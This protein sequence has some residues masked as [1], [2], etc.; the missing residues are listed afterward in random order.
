L[1]GEG[2][3]VI[4]DSKAA[5]PAAIRRTT[6]PESVDT[7]LAMKQ[8]AA[9]LRAKARHSPAIL[10]TASAYVA[11]CAAMG[12]QL[13]FFPLFL[14]ARGLSPEAIGLAI[15][16]P[17]AIRLVAMPLAGVLSDASGRP[18]L[19]LAALGLASAVTV[20]LVGLVHGTGPILLA[21][22]LFAV[23]WS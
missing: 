11:L 1:M 9:N 2:G 10:A 13:P 3:S 7:S 20:S 4:S 19:V 12:V 16:I 22:V 15:A 21:V 8:S 6:P 23:V 18:R 5:G 14:T 17:M